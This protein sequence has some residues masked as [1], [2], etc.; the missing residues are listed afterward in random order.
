LIRRSI[1]FALVALGMLLFAS[2]AQASITSNIIEPQGPPNNPGTA[3]DG[4]ISANCT[5][6]TP[7]CTP[8]TPGQFF[9]QAGGH[10]P[11][12]FTQFVVQHPTPTPLPSP[13][14]PAGAVAS[15]PTSS[16]KDL[17]VELPAGL[18]IN[19]L[20]GG[21]CPLNVFEPPAGLGCLAFDSHVGTENLEISSLENLG[22]LLPPSP[23]TGT[24]VPNFSL[25]PKFGEPALF[26]F[27]VGGAS[28]VF[29]ETEVAWQS[30]YHSSFVIRRIPNSAESKTA[31]V[32]SRLVNEGRSGADETFITNPTTCLS[33]DHYVTKFGA[34]SYQEPDPA[35]GDPLMPNSGR[36][37]SE[38]VSPT[39]CDLVPYDPTVEVQPGTTEVDSPASPTVTTKVPYVTGGANI[40][41]SDT[42][43]VKVTMPKG[44]GLNPAGSV[45]LVACTDSQFHMGER[46]NA[47]ACPAASIIGTAAIETPALPPGSLTG[48]VYIGEQKSTT[49]TSGEE[50]RVL[51]EAGSDRYG[52]HVRLIGHTKA[53]PATGQLTTEINETPQVPFESVTLHF[54]GTKAV[55]SSPPTCSTSAT[56]GEM[57]PWARPGTETSTPPSSF[58]LSSVPPV[59][60]GACP[61][62]LAARKF[63]PSYTT[64]S[65]STQGGAFSPFR[66]HIGRTDGQQEIKVVNAT[67]P[68][69]LTGRLT[70]VPYCG[71]SEIA[72]VQHE[73][74]QEQ[75]SESICP[76]SFVGHVTTESG[77]GANPLKLTGRAYL[78]GPYK[79]APL[80]MVVVT[81]AVS[82]PF[83]LGNVVVRV[84]LHV[85]PTTAQITAVSDVIP[86]VFGGV[87]LD[88]RSIDFNLD[89]SR[90]IVN[91][92]NCSAG[93]TT[94]T[95]NGGGADP[96]NPAAFSSYAFSAPFQATGC[97]N[98]GFK[99]TLVTKLSGPTKRNGNDQ[100]TATLTA[101]N[102][103]A[104]IAST[105]LALPHA[106]F[107]DQSHIKTVC[108]RPQLAANA[109]PASSVYGQAEATTPLLEEPLKG[110]VYLV[111]GG[112]KLPDLVADL[113][114]Q[115]NI[116]LHG[117]I[118]SQNGGIKTVFDSVPDAAVSKFV[119]KMAGG[120][121]SLIVNSTNI[122]KGK[123]LAKL[124]ITAQNGALVKN[125]K[126]KLNLA[127]CGKT[128][129]HKK[130]KH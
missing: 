1:A 75:R 46:I 37:E 41:E 24:Q 83:D 97:N 101:R 124:N 5:T 39:G 38:G 44:M 58:T 21:Q 61:A 10:P 40:S 73:S 19:P 43:N 69:G 110:N 51:I 111:P 50:F 92:T 15:I 67:L 29:L 72:A 35:E 118:S 88:I 66:V 68:R 34:D 122:C 30:D 53:D 99:P 103:D 98:L 93:A 90:F 115:I 106:F 78:A 26:G 127:S 87:K 82:G 13:P 76:A 120:K 85:D 17:R 121:K 6:D 64:K 23:T 54:N 70:G 117:V 123:Q 86:D 125:N 2:A 8:E 32:L 49:P 12:G 108:T 57:E 16:I 96:T 81:P 74:G 100:L 89:R 28:K 33:P 59:T 20:S 91:P 107:V 80:S 42:K 126:Y 65:D 7:Q 60:G 18:A 45:G 63:L 25:V 112:H 128:K 48:N 94:G 109:C 9:K 62:T 56:Q 105:S 47:N 79:G 11:I 119:L 113:R 71:E 31:T 27:V 36:L 22:L 84:A 77:T 4:W 55:L 52:I 114:G 104:N 130:H 102:G 95:L 3:A 14:F 129:K 116:Q